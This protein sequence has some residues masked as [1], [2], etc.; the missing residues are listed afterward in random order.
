M[1]KIFDKC[2][3]INDLNQYF[4][5]HI[6]LPHKVTL[7]NPTIYVTYLPNIS[8]FPVVFLDIL[9][10]NNVKIGSLVLKY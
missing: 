3:S 9:T 4:A 6:S 1:N 7:E 2:F 5:F 10:N 8:N